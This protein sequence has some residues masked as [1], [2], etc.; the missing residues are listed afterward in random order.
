M[1]EQ[2]GGQPPAGWYP[3]GTGQV[4]Y[5]DGA[6]WTEHVQPAQPEVPAPAPAAPAAPVAEEPF[7]K[8]PAALAVIG[9]VLL[10][11]I[12]GA[13]FALIGGSDDDSPAVASP[14]V[15]TSA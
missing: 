10:L 2:T 1:T 14:G 11:V 15:G 8:K 7:Y 5:W 13:A 3:D 9:A 4:R 6:A 12:G